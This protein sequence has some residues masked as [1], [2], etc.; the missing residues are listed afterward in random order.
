VDT[1]TDWVARST[2]IMQPSH[3]VFTPA[4]TVSPHLAGAAAVGTK[5]APRRNIRRR[6][7]LIAAVSRSASAQ[8]LPLSRLI[9][10][11][12]VTVVTH[13]GRYQ[14]SLSV[15]APKYCMFFFATTQTQA[16]NHGN[17]IG[18]PS[19]QLMARATLVSCKLKVTR[20]VAALI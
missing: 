10:L 7:T 14:D 8:L 20:K 12:I 2:V 9:S 1:G 3:A 4:P 5:Y 17:S 13:R 19:Y 16:L 6:S 11:I 18:G 15:G